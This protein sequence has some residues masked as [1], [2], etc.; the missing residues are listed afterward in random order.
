MTGF[1][2]VYGPSRLSRISAEGALFLLGTRAADIRTFDDI[3]EA[4]AWLASR[5]NTL[6]EKS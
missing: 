6:T 5:P 4:M 1:A 3:D 2:H